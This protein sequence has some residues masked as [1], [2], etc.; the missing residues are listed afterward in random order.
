MKIYPAVLGSVVAE[1]NA[2]LV[3]AGQE[4]DQRGEIF[5]I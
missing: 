3:I 5:A 4:V 2:P 1:R